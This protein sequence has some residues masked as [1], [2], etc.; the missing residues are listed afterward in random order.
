VSRAWQIIL[1][2]SPIIKPKFSAHY[3]SLILKQHHAS[4]QEL[5]AMTCSFKFNPKTTVLFATCLDDIAMPEVQRFE[6]YFAAWLP[7]CQKGS[8]LL[9]CTIFWL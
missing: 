6:H 5:I 2:D 9:D 4:S 1:K 3:S 8:W 7:D